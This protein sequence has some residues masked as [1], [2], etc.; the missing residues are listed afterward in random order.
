[1]IMIRCEARWIARMHYR[2]HG[3]FG[4]NHS[5]ILIP[6]NRMT[7]Q[8]R[9][10]LEREISYDEENG[11]SVDRKT[12]R[13]KVIFHAEG[14]GLIFKNGL[15]IDRVLEPTAEVFCIMMDRPGCRLEMEWALHEIDVGLCL[16]HDCLRWFC[17]NESEFL[18]QQ[19]KNTKL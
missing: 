14:S 13:D 16:R 19:T 3:P 8:V 4:V 17:A 11:L 15:T 10:C 12:P 2:C 1:M 6:G 5:V 7:W 9:G 18:K